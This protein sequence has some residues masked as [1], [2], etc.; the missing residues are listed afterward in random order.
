MTIP[1]PVKHAIAVAI[2]A[3]ALLLP[4]SLV[5]AQTSQA[6]GFASPPVFS[7]L[8]VAYVVF[9]GGSVEELEAANAASGASG[10]WAQDA[11]G[12]FSQITIGGPSFVNDRFRATF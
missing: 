10:A 4:A 12:R 3:A 7:K 5:G 6:P 9:L 2:L 8:G 11:S 1:I